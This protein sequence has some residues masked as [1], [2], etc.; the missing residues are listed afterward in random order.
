MY[1]VCNS[2]MCLRMTSFALEKIKYRQLKANI[3]SDKNGESCVSKSECKSL[4]YDPAPGKSFKD[5]RSVPSR[6][7]TPMDV[8]DSEPVLL[9][10]LF[11]SFYCPVFLCG[12]VIIYSD[13]H[14]QVK[15]SFR[16]LVCVKDL[17]DIAKQFTKITFYSL[18]IDF[19][20]DVLYVRQHVSS[21][22]VFDAVSVTALWGIIYY[23]FMLFILAYY[24]IFGVSI[25]FSRFD[26]VAPLPPPRCVFWV[27][28]SACVWKHL[29][30]GLS[31]FLKTAV[32]IPLGG[33]R[34]GLARQISALGLTFLFS[35]LWHG[36]SASMAV[37]CLGSY[38]GTLMDAFVE[39][40]VLTSEL[41]S[42][43]IV[44]L[45]YKTSQFLEKRGTRVKLIK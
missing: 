5:E 30:V 17:P 6:L 27:Y 41:V 10:L 36:A 40:S 25:Q 12:P 29:D 2:L 26:G 14:S 23:D 20:F 22:E 28:S 45:F 15:A 37:V 18:I 19:L 13:F 11:Y 33:S 44:I 7:I 16:S 42:N 4:G 31:N 1:F 34:N 35:M 39:R 9:D 8:V 38:V 24:I 3:K 32:F 21:E 43:V